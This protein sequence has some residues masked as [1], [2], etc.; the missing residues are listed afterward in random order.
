MSTLTIRMPDAM[1]ARRKA[2]AQARDVSM[3]RLFDEWATAALAQHGALTLYT[4]RAER[5]D[6][7]VD[8][9]LLDKLARH[10]SKGTEST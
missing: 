7:T 4:A 8:P 5:G 1:N 9:K 10:V 2:L 3:N 6:A